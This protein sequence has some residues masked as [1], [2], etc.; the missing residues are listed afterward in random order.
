LENSPE[1]F[2]KFNIKD[3]TLKH[4][5]EILTKQ[6]KREE[7][8]QADWPIDIFKITIDLIGLSN[9]YTIKVERP[10]DKVTKERQTSDQIEYFLARSWVPTMINYTRNSWD[11]EDPT[12]LIEF[13]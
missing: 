9:D 6:F 3:L 2:V 5:L 11:H 4:I 13:F 12:I 10:E 8:I 1:N 7:D